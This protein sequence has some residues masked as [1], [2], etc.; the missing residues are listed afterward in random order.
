MRK[1]A[2]VTLLLTASCRQDMHDQPRE[3]PLKPSRFFRDGKSG[4]HPVAGTVARGQYRPRTPLFTGR[5]EGAPAVTSLVPPAAQA[6][7]NKPDADF[8]PDI[9]REIPI[10]LTEATLRRGQQRYAMYCLPC[11][12]LSGAGDGIVVKRGFLAPPSYHSDRLREAPA[13]HFFEVITY[14]Y[15]AMFS[16]ASR[17]GVEDR[18][19]ISAYLRALQLSQWSDLK[20]IPEAERQRLHSMPQEAAP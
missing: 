12:G 16:Y 19:A 7:S 13:G 14:G 4:R 2:F 18:W 3:E 17:I 10:P 15:G 1:A 6:L 9:V 11:H 5:R 8:S 20:D